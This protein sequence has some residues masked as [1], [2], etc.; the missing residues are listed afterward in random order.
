MRVEKRKAND[1]PDLVSSFKTAFIGT[2]GAIANLCIKYAMYNGTS[3]LSHWQA[4]QFWALYQ[5]IEHYSGVHYYGSDLQRVSDNPEFAARLPN[6]HPVR[7]MIS[8][9]PDL[10]EQD[11]MTAQERFSV[12]SL[13][14]VDQRDACRVQ[15]A[16]TNGIRRTEVL[17]AYIAMNLYGSL[18]ASFDLSALIASKPGGSA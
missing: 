13:V 7:T 3:R 14:V 15:C 12:A 8:E 11:Y 6:R 17:P 18:K 1:E 5:C 16:L 4:E 2:P 9:R 10:T